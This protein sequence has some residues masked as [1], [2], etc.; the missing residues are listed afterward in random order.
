[1]AFVSLKSRI[2]QITAELEAKMEGVERAGAE[3]I[4]AGAKMRVPVDEGDL[5]AA[6]HTDAQAEGTY[7]TAGDSDTFY[8]HMVENGTVSQPP[9]PFLVPAAEAAR[10]PIVAM[11]IKVLRGL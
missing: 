9:Q 2:P 3:L 11:A 7:V 1:M 8:G 6:I 10:E 5:R 4:E